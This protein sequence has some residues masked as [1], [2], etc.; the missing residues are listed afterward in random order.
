MKSIKTCF[1]IAILIGCSA[2]SACVLLDPCYASDL[3]TIGTSNLIIGK[4]TG[5]TIL[6]IRNFNGNYDTVKV[7]NEDWTANVA[8]TISLDGSV[9]FDF[10][11]P[12][13]EN[14]IYD[15]LISKK[16]FMYFNYQDIDTIAIDFKLYRDACGKPRENYFKVAYND[17]VYFEGIVAR[18]VR[19][20]K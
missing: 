10:Y 7:Y 18:G 9:Y 6:H 14:R 1:A 16:F 17:S 2:L 20:I 8:S 5:D 13:R 19:F 12:S 15:Q 3:N 11:D 4:A